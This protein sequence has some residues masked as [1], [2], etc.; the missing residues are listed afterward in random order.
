[1]FREVEAEILWNNDNTVTI[2]T[3]TPTT[4]FVYCN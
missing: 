4:G 2:T 1:M 3:N